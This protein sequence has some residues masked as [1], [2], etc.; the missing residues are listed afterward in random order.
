M[1]TTPAEKFDPSRDNSDGRIGACVPAANHS[2]E[3]EEAGCFALGD[4]I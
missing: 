2:R 3:G 4:G 1:S